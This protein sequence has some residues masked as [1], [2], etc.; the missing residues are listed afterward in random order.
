MPSLLSKPEGEAL[1]FW[2]LAQWNQALFVHFFASPHTAQAINRLHVTAESLRTASGTTALLAERVRTLFILTVRKAI[3][4]RSLGHDAESRAE[5]WSVRADEVPPFLSHLL[6][7]CMVANDLADELKSEGDFR[8][9]ADTILKA[10]VH[11][12]L[13]RLRPLWELLAEWLSDRHDQD[14]HVATLRLPPIPISGHHSIIGYPLRLSVPTRRDQ[15]LLAGLL[16]KNN[17]A[18]DEPAV[19]EVVTLFQTKSTKFSPLF[20]DLYREFVDG[21]KKLSR[22]TL[23]QMTFWV[24]VREIALST[25]SPKGRNTLLSRRAWKWKMRMAISGWTPPVTTNAP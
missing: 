19:L 5:H 24:A 11:H 20:R 14:S 3:A 21:M 1:E 23:A 22:T 12:G 25:S 15:N 18:G 9:K 2:S 13:P 8:K 17:L 6:L 7:T 16:A 4:H 10:G